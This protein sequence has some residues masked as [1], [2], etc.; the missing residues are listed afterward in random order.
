[1]PVGHRATEA[2]QENSEI[3]VP[4]VTSPIRRLSVIGEERIHFKQF[5]PLTTFLGFPGDVGEAGDKGSIGRAI[6]GPPGDQGY[7]GNLSRQQQ[8]QLQSNKPVPPFISCAQVSQE[9]LELSKT[10]ARDLQEIPVSLESRAEWV[11]PGTRDLLASA[12]RQPVREQRRPGNP[13]TP[14]P[15]KTRLPAT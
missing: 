11:E 12:T 4:E 3:Q 10:A 9:Y 13:P 1:M 6:D 7:Q 8:A 15:I 2:F 14:K 5:P